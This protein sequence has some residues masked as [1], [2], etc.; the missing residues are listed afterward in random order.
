MEQSTLNGQ[1]LFMLIFVHII[2]LYFISSY[3]AKEENVPN[4]TLVPDVTNMTSVV[5]FD[6]PPHEE[7]VVCKAGNNDD[8]L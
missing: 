8:T 3:M 4:E 2:L 7:L 6:D 1:S 5:A